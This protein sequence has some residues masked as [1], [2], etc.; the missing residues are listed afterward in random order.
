[1][2]TLN[3]TIPYL[4]SPFISSTEN[5]PIGL[6]N[7]YTKTRAKQT[8]IKLIQYAKYTGRVYMSQI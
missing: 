3:P 6:V 2:G 1:M 5:K 4:I 7:K 8:C